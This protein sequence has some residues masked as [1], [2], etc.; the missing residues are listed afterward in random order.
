MFRL[1]GMV[2]VSPMMNIFTSGISAHFGDDF[3]DAIKTL[4]ENSS[5]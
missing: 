1:I 3:D 4:E 2:K 5:C